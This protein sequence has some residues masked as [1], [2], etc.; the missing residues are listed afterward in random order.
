M[1]NKVKYIYH[2]LGLGDHIACNGL[3]RTIVEK[4]DL[5]ILFTLKKNIKNVERLYKGQKGIKFI[6]VEGD[7]EVRQ[8]MNN[9]SFLDFMII[10]HENLHK[11][12]AKDISARFD[13]VMYKM[14]KV[15]FP[16]KWDMFK[17][18]RDL[19]REKEVFYKELEL[20]DEDEYIFVH[21]DNKRP[22]PSNKLP[23]GIKIVR[24]DRM[25]ISI[26]D[27]LYVIEKAKEVHCI[28]SSFF[29]LIECM[30]LR[31][32]NNLFFHKYVKYHLVGEGGTPTFV[33]PWNVLEPDQKIGV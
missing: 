22:I 29:N 11:E 5:T 30:K 27:F 2:H 19:N 12:L 14:A 24:P 26:Y 8:F 32:D 3:V 7:G 13:Q 20:T 6:T 4:N 25:D 1:L 28:D 31:K 23:S 16:H 9:S 18:E 21:D 15:P 33:L 10:G 17:F